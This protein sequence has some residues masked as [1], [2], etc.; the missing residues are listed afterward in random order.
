MLLS[1]NWIEDFVDLSGLDKLEL[2]HKLSLSTAEV[3]SKALT[4]RA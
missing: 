3:S 4:F 2:I 1:M